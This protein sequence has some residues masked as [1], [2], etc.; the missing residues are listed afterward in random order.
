MEIKEAHHFLYLL[1]ALLSA[2][3]PPVISASKREMRGNEERSSLFSLFGGIS[4]GRHR[5]PEPYGSAWGPG[6]IK[7]YFVFRE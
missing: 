3:L 5:F 6:G 2:R 4:F 1:R 7:R